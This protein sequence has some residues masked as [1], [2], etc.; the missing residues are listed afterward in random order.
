MAYLGPPL[1]ST[2]NI[3]S[4]V[5]KVRATSIGERFTLVRK[6]ASGGF[7]FVYLGT[8][9]PVALSFVSGTNG[10][11]V[12]LDTTDG[13]EV[14]LKLEHVSVDP[15]RLEEEADAYIDL[16]GLFGL[17]E[18]FWYGSEGDYNILA[19][20]LLGPTLADL[21]EFCGGTFSL[22]TTLMILHQILAIL[23]R[24]HSRHYFHGDIKPDN[25]LMGLG[26]QGNMIYLTDLGLALHLPPNRRRLVPAR[27]GNPR[28]IGTARY[29][30]IRQHFGRGKYFH[31]RKSWTESRRGYRPCTNISLTVAFQPYHHKKILSPWDT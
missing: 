5:R 7:G 2:P 31:Y 15:S 8:Q 23:E 20:Q 12:A 21:L 30:S 9:L 18:T 11:I 6:I 14:A 16:A 27:T 24:F 25:F 29:A 13:R 17:P 10:P 22:K 1:L 3:D 26:E 28:L 19:L 4:F